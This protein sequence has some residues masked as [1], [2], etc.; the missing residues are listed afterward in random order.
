[1][2]KILKFIDAISEWT[3]RIFGWIIVVLM[4]LVVVEVFM[5]RFLNAPTIWNFDVTKQLYALYFMIVAGYALL[6]NS[7]VSVDILH[8][9]LSSRGRAVLDVISYMIFFFPFVFVMLNEGIKF[10]GNSWAM[11]EKVWGMF[12]APIYPVKTIIPITAGLLLLQG[13]AIFVR[14]VYFAIKGEELC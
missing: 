1:M 5:R 9:K 11:R 13:M 2:I 7:H 8:M 4:F 14:R 3:G 6:H 10:A 12:Q